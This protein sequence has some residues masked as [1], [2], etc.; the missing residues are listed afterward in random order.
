MKLGRNYYPRPLLERDEKLR[1]D[2]SMIFSTS[3]FITEQCSDSQNKVPT[4]VLDMHAI[5]YWI[6]RKHGTT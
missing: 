1:D 5:W 6:K 2:Y 3:S 4:I